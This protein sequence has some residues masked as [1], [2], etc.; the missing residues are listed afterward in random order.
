[1]L[2]R[3]CYA[4][5]QKKGFPMPLST[6]KDRTFPPKDLRGLLCHR[7]TIGHGRLIG[8]SPSGRECE[9]AIGMAE[10]ADLG[11]LHGLD[12]W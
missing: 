1:M 5:P 6:V 3:K 7:E 9:D 2:G 4:G 11:F 10:V 8:Q 12:Y